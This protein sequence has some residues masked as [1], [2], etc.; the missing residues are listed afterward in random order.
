MKTVNTVISI[1]IIVFFIVAANQDH[2]K[3]QNSNVSKILESHYKAINIKQLSKI[4]TIKY[5]GTITRNDVMPLEIM[6]K[7]PNKYFMI[8]DVADITGKQVFDGTIAWAV[9]PWTGNSNAVDITGDNLTNMKFLADF[10][11]LLVDWKKKDCSVTI[12]GEEIIEGNACHKV[13]LIRPDQVVEYYFI[14]KKDFL[15]KQ[16]SSPRTIRGKETVQH[17]KY[18][19][20]KNIEGIVFPME[21]E[22][23]FGE[24][25]YALY[26]FDKI[27]LNLNIEDNTFSKP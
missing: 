9:S 8:F 4:G 24:Q 14:D 5:T 15:L 17:I 18:R 13:K 1:F 20:F 19:N 16:R 26:Q 12:D 25:V 11:G 22:I 27:E 7:R 21:Q 23:F 3:A 6:K 10:D 2:A